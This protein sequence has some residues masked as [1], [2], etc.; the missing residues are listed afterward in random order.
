MPVIPEDKVGKIEFC[1]NHTTPWAANAVAI[2]TTAA[3]V[4][5][6]TTK[7]TAARTAYNA[8][9]AAQSAA[10]AATNT[11]NMAV[12]AMAAAAAD[13]IKQVRVKASTAGNSVY[14]LAEIPAPATPSPMG[15]L[16]KPSDFKVQLDQTGALNLKWKNSN[17]RGAT[18]V[19]YQIWR[20]LGGVGDF[21]YLG[22]VGDKKYTDD[23]VPAGT[24]Q[25]Q[26]QIQAV[27][28]TSVGPFALFVVNFGAA[29]GTGGGGAS[30]TEAAPAK[31]AA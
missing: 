13:I 23:G 16:G 17:P 25:V 10:K 22:G 28:S 15:P 30:V 29:G 12:D 3:A 11:F 8:Q 31:L 4:T 27:R 21:A 5:D 18:G 14:S 20:R 1:E 19:V 24:A 7:T 26:Y 2:G 9:Q 6:L